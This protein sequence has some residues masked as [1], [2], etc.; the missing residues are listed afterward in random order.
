M[1]KPAVVLSRTPGQARRRS[2]RPAISC[3]LCHRRKIRCN[4]ARPCS[5]CLRSKS[6]AAGCVYE[7]SVPKLAMTDSAEPPV[8]RSEMQSPDGALDMNRTQAQEAHCSRDGPGSSSA[9]HLS[10]SSSLA[11]STWS[12]VSTPATAS[13]RLSDH[14]VESLRSRLKIDQ[15]ERQLAKH[16][17]PSSL[18]SP[19]PAPSP[20]ADSDM[21]II[22]SRLSGTIYILSHKDVSTGPDRPPIAHGLSLKTRLLGQSH[23]AVS[24]APLVRCRQS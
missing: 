15:L 11:A 2:Q 7:N 19:A 24:T 10:L 18:Q 8:G 17:H 14:G 13:G 6:G 12:E 3:T 1:D 22:D 4:R 9:L 20:G 5:S 16:L 21:D 23:W